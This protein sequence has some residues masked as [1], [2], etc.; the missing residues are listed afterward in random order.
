VETWL[1]CWPPGPLD[2]QKTSSTSFGR[3]RCRR[4]LPARLTGGQVRGLPRKRAECRAF[5]VEGSWC[6]A[7]NTDARQ[8]YSRHCL[9]T[10]CFPCA[11][12]P[13]IST[14]TFSGAAE[15]RTTKARQVA[16]QPTETA[17]GVAPRHRAPSWLG[18]AAPAS[19][20]GNEKRGLRPVT[21]RP[22]APPAL[23]RWPGRGRRAA[24]GRFPTS[25][26]VLARGRDP[27]FPAPRADNVPGNRVWW[28]VDPSARPR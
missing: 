22:P 24:R 3:H 20:A 1:T 2:R 28:R 4:D 26:F 7:R 18:Q 15:L 25:L 8:P 10:A 5:L 13:Q 23:R 21:L 16:L 6:A 14:T 9:K 12:I 17:P 27:R 11:R 19:T